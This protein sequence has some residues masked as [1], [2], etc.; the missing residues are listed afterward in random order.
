[1][2]FVPRGHGL[3]FWVI[4]EIRGLEAIFSGGINKHEPPPFRLHVS[5]RWRE[6]D[7]GR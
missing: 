3:V 7:A 1:M 2:C 5:W 4:A 6:E